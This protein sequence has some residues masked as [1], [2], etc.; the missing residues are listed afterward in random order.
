[1]AEKK[2]A[3]EKKKRIY[4]IHKAYKI[5]GDKLIRKGG[6]CPKCEGSL[7]AVHKDRKSCGRCGYMEKL[8][9]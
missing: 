7:L 1:M 5:E 8:K 4:R 9:A 6:F 2:K 3:E